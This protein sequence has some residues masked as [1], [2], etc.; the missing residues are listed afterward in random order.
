LCPQLP[1]RGGDGIGLLSRFRLQIV[2]EQ[3]CELARASWCIAH[4]QN[5]PFLPA[6]ILVTAGL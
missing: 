3:A 2:A 6:P 5:A 1:V 4:A